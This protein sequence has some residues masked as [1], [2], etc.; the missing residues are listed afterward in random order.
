MK[1]NKKINNKS[2]FLYIVS[3]CNFPGFYKVGVT[4]NVSSRINNYQ[5]SSPHRNYKIEHYV[6]HPTAYVAERKIKEMINPFALSIR[7]EW[8]E[9]S[10][11]MLISRLNEQ[12]ECES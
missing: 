8:Y 7:H 6:F 3:N 9:I 10:L 4:K 11:P 1:Q 12:V 2:G 5:T